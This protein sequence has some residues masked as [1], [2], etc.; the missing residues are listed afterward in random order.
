MVRDDR[1]RASEASVVILNHLRMEKPC[2]VCERSTKYQCVRCPVAVCAICAPETPQ[3]TN[4]KEYTPMRRVGICK[5]CEK[6]GE[7]TE[8]QNIDEIPHTSSSETE[9]RD[10]VS[11]LKRKQWTREQKL[12]FIDLYKKFNSKA[13]AAREFKARYPAVRGEVKHLGYN[14]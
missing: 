9:K 10:D 5:G 4:E 2:S 6:S 8:A 1:T 3:T 13:R 14:R 12:E 7:Q 11:S